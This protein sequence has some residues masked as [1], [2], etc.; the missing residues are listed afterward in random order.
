MF[1]ESKDLT[2]GRVKDQSRRSEDERKVAAFE[3]LLGRKKQLNP[4]F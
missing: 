2:K 3:D 4:S 1:S